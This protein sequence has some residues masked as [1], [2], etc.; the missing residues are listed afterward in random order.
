MNTLL[1]PAT[2]RKSTLAP[3]RLRRH[4]DYQRVYEAS[5]KYHSA[6]LSYFFRVRP[7]DEQPPVVG[8]RVGLTVGKVMGKAVE[9]N[10]LKRRMRE[11]AR[12]HLDLLL[13]PQPAAIDLVLHPRKSVATIAFA[14][15]EQELRQVF[16]KVL[17]LSAHPQPVP[18][19]R[20]P[21]PGKRS[22]QPKP[23]AGLQS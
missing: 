7:A 19:P 12:L 14:A 15:L 11:A 1:T 4:A 2:L 3:F 21:K 23:K 5:R 17:A 20:P 16:A 13:D 6:S 8:P 10:R 9:R 22:A 18:G